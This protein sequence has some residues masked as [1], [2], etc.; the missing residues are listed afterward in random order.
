MQKG[1]PL[2]HKEPVRKPVGNSCVSAVS[3]FIGSS[4]V[5]PA[6]IVIGIL[7]VFIL[8]I[9]NISHAVSMSFRD[10][11]MSMSMEELLNLNLKPDDILHSQ[12]TA[13]GDYSQSVYDHWFHVSGLPFD[14]L[15]R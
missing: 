6:P 8:S 12:I 15:Y 3:F 9:A 11:T 1:I 2:V 13:V 14:A 5:E 10:V 4:V 7:T